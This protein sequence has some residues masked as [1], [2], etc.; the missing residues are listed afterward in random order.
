MILLSG[1]VV[2]YTLLVVDTVQVVRGWEV[3]RPLHNLL[4]LR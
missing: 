4:H 2:M 1:P 3:I